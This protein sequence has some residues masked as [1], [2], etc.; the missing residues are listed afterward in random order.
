MDYKSVAVKGTLSAFLTA[1]T[2]YFDML[3][4]PIIVLIVIMICDYISGMI[5]AYLTSKLSSKVGLKG[6]IK[7]LCYFFA[8]AAAMGVDWII[9]YGFSGIGINIPDN[10]TIALIVTIWLILNEIISIL[11]NLSVIG[12]PLPKFLS[13]IVKKLKVSMDNESEDK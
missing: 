3:A 6:I 9:S 1:L 11:E 13:K 10:M 8:V 4:V 12:I 5:K 2:I 7:K